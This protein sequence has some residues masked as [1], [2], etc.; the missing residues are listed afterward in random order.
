MFEIELAAYSANKQMLVS[1]LLVQPIVYLLLLGGGLES[2]VD[3]EGKYG[4]VTSYLSFILP[5]LFALQG[6]GTVTHVIYRATIDR[7][8]GLLAFKKLAGGGIG[9]SGG[10][11]GS[12]CRRGVVPGHCADHFGGA[13]GSTS[14]QLEFAVG[15]IPNACAQRVLASAGSDGYRDHIQLPAEGHGNHPD[16]ASIG[17]QRSHLLSG[18]GRKQIHPMDI[19][20]QSTDLS[21][22]SGAG[23]VSPGGVLLATPR[24]GRSNRSGRDRGHLHNGPRRSSLGRRAI[25]DG[26]PIRPPI[27]SPVTPDVQ[28]RHR[29]SSPAMAARVAATYLPLLS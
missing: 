5:G 15:G 25:S 13:H 27:S 2:V 20:A 9:L 22:R 17:V 6:L 10:S 16:D 7:R 24:H 23:S 29:V 18:R 26:R 19:Q 21:G 4:N 3:L 12:S 8:W 14:G 1:S 28:S 11:V